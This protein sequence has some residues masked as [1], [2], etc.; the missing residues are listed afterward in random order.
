MHDHK[1]QLASTGR[2]R[3]TAQPPSLLYHANPRR[4]VEQIWRH[5]GLLRQ[6]IAR[7]LVLRYRGS[8][9]SL[10]WAFVMPTLAFA[11]YAFVFGV[12]LRTRWPGAGSSSLID[13]SLAVFCGLMVFNVFSDSLSR[14][15]WLIAGV[16]SYVKKIVFPL[17]VLP[18]AVVSAALVHGLVSLGLLA[19]AV[20]VLRG[21]LPW[22]AIFLPVILLPLLALCLGFSWLV[23]SLGL[24]FRD[25]APSLVLVLH[26]LMLGTPI[27]Y[28]LEVV[29]TPWRGWLGLNPLAVVVENARAALLWGTP[30]SLLGLSLLYLVSGAILLVG[31]LWFMRTRWAFAD[32]A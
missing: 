28:P 4:F 31:Y 18:V 5:R 15:S 10:I 14:S 13:F 26:L 8:G 3:I 23:S 32:V 29:P 11:A 12:V 25:L 19:V 9:L 6:Q 27:F 1:T 21:G 2:T 24:F 7:E 17:E 22:T 16:P 20:I 30:P